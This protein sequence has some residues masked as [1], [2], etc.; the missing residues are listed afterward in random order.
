MSV[1]L[2]F[3]R[4]YFEFKLVMREVVLP[5]D[6]WVRQGFW[7]NISPTLVFLLNETGFWKVI[8]VR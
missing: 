6:E 5:V 3:H 8:L 1:L 7:F 2:I 4:S